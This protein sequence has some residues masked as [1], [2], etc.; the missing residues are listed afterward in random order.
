MSPSIFNMYA[1]TLRHPWPWAIA[2]LGKRI[3]NR[4]WKPGPDLIGKRFALHGGAKPKPTEFRIAESIAEDLAN[5]HDGIAQFRDG[6]SWIIEGIFAVVTVRQVLTQSTDPWF[7]G[8]FGW[9][10]ED[11]ILLDHPIPCRGSQG[12]WRIPDRQQI[13][14]NKAIDRKLTPSA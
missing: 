7:Q 10:L 5:F 8:P 14:L 6:S 11:V 4:G 13:V 2:K 12:F 1:L 9:L 3:E